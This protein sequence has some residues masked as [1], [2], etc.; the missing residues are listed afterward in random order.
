M[1]ANGRKAASGPPAGRTARREG[2]RRG[3]RAGSQRTLLTEGRRV[4]RRVR[5]TRQEGTD[6]RLLPR[7]PMAGRPAP[8][9]SP[10]GPT[11]G[12]G[13]RDPASEPR[14]ARQRLLGTHR[15]PTAPRRSQ[16][17]CAS[18]CAVRGRRASGLRIEA[19]NRAELASHRRR[20]EGRARKAAPSR[21]MLPA[22]PGTDGAVGPA[23]AGSASRAPTCS[24]TPRAEGP[25]S[26]TSTGALSC[27]LAGSGPFTRANSAQRRWDKV[28]PLC[29]RSH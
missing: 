1:A 28:C 17:G 24:P 14:R 20:P 9:G 12:A 2:G 26:G 13:G 19:V 18:T 8:N 23:V 21:P 3:A 15:R 10:H 16:R 25:G 4:T 6:P 29:R 11:P 22:G 7:Q 27:A 5:F